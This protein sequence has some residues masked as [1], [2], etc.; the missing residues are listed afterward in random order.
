MH[1]SIY[2]EFLSEMVKFT[3]TLQVGDG[4]ADG[5]FLGPIQNE[6]QY[7]RVNG[8]IEEL[9]KDSMKVAVGGSRE[10]SKKAGKGYFIKPTIV[11]N[12]ADNSRLVVEEPFG[13]RLLPSH[14]K[15]DQY[16]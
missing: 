15:P 8:F 9:E 14:V 4:F 6:M 1:E 13:T 5:T 7:N 3:K 16:H 2:D 10:E 11:D 12:P